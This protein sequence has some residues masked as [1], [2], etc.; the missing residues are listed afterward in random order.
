M[1]QETIQAS[2]FEELIDVLKERELRREEVHKIKIDLCKKYSQ[3]KI[4]TNIEILLHA[5]PEDLSKLHHLQTKPTRSISGVAPLAIMSKPARCPHGVCTYC[6]GGPGSA[7][8]D[9]PQ[10]YTGAEPSTMRSARAGYDPYRVVFYRLEQ[11]VVLGHECDKVDVI[12]QGGTFPAMDYDYQTEFVR[13]IFAGLNDFSDLFFKD[14]KMDVLKFREFFELP[15]DINNEERTK[16][17]QD[18]IDALKQKNTGTS[19]EA[20]QERNEKSVIRCIGLT[21]ET[22][23]DWGMLKHGNLMLEQGCTRVE[24]GVQTVYDDVLKAVHRG[25]D[26][27][28]TKKSIQQLR[29]LGFKLN[30]HIMPGLPNS[31]IERDLAMFKELFANSDYMP[32]MLKVYPCMVMPGTALENS[33]KAGKFKPIETPQAAELI[34][35]LQRIVPAW[36]RIMRVQRDIPTYRTTAGVDK[37][38]LRQYVDKISAEK[39]IVCKC[40]RCREIGRREATSA[41]EISITDYDAS[42]GKEF[43]ISADAGDALV[44]F[45]RLRFPKECLRSEITESSA[46]VRELHV[47]GSAVAIG[48]RA[49]DAIQHKGWGKKLLAEA[50]SIAAKHGRD[51]IV[52]ISGVGA[53][54]YYRK[55]GYTQEGPY[56]VK[57]LD[58]QEKSKSQMSLKA[59]DE[60]IE[61]PSCGVTCDI[62]EMECPKCGVRL[63]TQ[64]IDGFKEGIC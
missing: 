58:A 4:P 60:Q 50:E 37:T 56:M 17:L 41:T 49:H 8:G 13:D 43:F 59:E 54:R 64:E 20:E 2:F 36:C 33:F 44:G 53:R 12:I 23:P 29:D 35:E 6:P 11:F 38:N 19:L 48:K 57:M 26:L 52:V 22:K 63:K 39:G 9:V 7:F 42:G 28:D 30:F 40:I 14:G 61:C 21:I 15:G 3:K 18:K 27:A 1:S 45:C 51:K 34:A 5:K 10:S 46:I 25:H 32:D 31:D 47:F 24:L 62:E 55:L 16:S